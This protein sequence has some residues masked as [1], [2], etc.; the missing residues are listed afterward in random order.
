MATEVLSVPRKRVGR[1]SC[2]F[3]AMPLLESGSTH[4]SPTRDR[5]APAEVSSRCRLEKVFRKLGMLNA[6]AVVAVNRLLSRKD[7]A[8]YLFISSV[9]YAHVS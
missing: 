8:K 7:L 6:L 2:V 5:C 1:V 9:A 3:A 4:R